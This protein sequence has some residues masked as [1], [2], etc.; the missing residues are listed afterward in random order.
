[1]LPTLVPASRTKEQ[2]VPNMR[3]ATASR[4][5]AVVGWLLA[6]VAGIAVG[7]WLFADT[8]PRFPLR[9]EGGIG[10]PRLSDLLGVVGS[11]V[12]QRAPWMIPGLLFETEHS[13]VMRYPSARARFHV[14]IVPRRDIRDAG[15]LAAGDQPY[16]LDAYA[17]IG[18]L[19]RD[20]RLRDYQ[21]LTRGPDDQFV[22]YLHFHL[23]AK[24]GRTLEEGPAPV[25]PDSGDTDAGNQP[26]RLRA[27]APRCASDAGRRP[28]AR[29]SR[30]R[31]T[32]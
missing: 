17:I 31:R 15:S 30:C 7:G 24:D 21:V 26:G 13:I 28:R 2:D 5:W 23:I 9:I 3:T 20:Y 4:R 12:V 19:V 29:Q 32:G 11:A 18:R 25:P 6:F 10:P 27:A 14:V 8:Q 1:M 22:R 16:L